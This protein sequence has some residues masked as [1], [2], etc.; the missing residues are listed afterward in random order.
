[1]I[2]RLRDL[3]IGRIEIMPG[4]GVNEET[5]VEL[6]DFTDASEFHVTGRSLYP[7]EMIFRNP[8]ISM[9]DN[10]EVPEYDQ[11]ITDP[12]RIKRIVELANS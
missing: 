4:S 11:W 3:A 6:R 2:R 1:M 9:G 12:E 7:G 10:K 5:I 8:D